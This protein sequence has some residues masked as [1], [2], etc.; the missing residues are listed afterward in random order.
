MSFYFISC[1]GQGQG[2]NPGPHAGWAS[3]LPPS[4]TPAPGFCTHVTL[5]CEQ[6]T[7]DCGGQGGWLWGLSRRSLG[8]LWSRTPQVVS[9]PAPQPASCSP[10]VRQAEAV[11]QGARRCGQQGSC[12]GG[13]LLAGETNSCV[14]APDDVRRPGLR[15][16]E[17]RRPERSVIPQIQG[18]RPSGSPGAAGRFPEIFLPETRFSALAFD[19]LDGVTVVVGVVPRTVG[20]AAP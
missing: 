7:H 6:L 8:V 11:D 18:A 3:A 9:L 5:S 12:L 15:L 13:P 14:N 16:N 1:F 17:G 10:A 4:C 2:W 20:S 19:I